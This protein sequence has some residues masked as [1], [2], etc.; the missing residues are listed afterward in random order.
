MRS[1]AVSILLD[2]ETHKLLEDGL[3]A[4]GEGNA[5]QRVDRN[6]DEESSCC[7]TSSWAARVCTRLSE[8][9]VWWMGRWECAGQ[10]TRA[11]FVDLGACPLYEC[12]CDAT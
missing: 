4:S 8:R 10:Q 2:N 1:T 5:A 9:V 12:V 7:P 6:A 11:S 3:G